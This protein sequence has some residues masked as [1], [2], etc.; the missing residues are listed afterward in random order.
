MLGARTSAYHGALLPRARFIVGQ[1]LLHSAA[2]TRWFGTAA[3]RSSAFPRAP[4][5]RDCPVKAFLVGSTGMR[6]VGKSGGNA[7]SS[8]F[9]RRSW[10]DFRRARTALWCLLVALAVLGAVLHDLMVRSPAARFAGT[11][12]MV[13]VVAYPLGFLLGF[14][15]PRCGEAYLATG[16]LMDFLGLGR[17]LWSR[18]CGS[19]SLRAGEAAPSSRDLPDSRPAT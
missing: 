8:A 17:I 3:L 6:D 16:G 1:W 9:W 2:C 7:P 18:R 12:A 11:S 5:A 4:A 10:R 15:C 14:K 13:L 19:C